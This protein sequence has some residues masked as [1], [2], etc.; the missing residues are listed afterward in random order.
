[1]M[2]DYVYSKIGKGKNF[3]RFEV[4]ARIHWRT[5]E[6]NLYY[7]ICHKIPVI[8]FIDDLNDIIPEEDL[9]DKKHIC[10]QR[11]RWIKQR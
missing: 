4:E 3:H 7:H 1:M 8:F 5:Q 10:H 2:P 9:H 6:V 11:L